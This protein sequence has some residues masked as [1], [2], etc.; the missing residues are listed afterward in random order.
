MLRYAMLASALLLTPAAASAQQIP[1]EIGQC[2]KTTITEHGTR[3]QGVADSGDIVGYPGDLYGI[4][5]GV[6]DGLKG[7]R[8][9]D[10]VKLCLVSVP[11][12]CPPGDDRG[13]VYSGFNPRTGLSWELPDAGHLCGGA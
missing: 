11:G 8:V 2:V 10:P 6:V 5:Y 12:D 4:S 9:G 1:T 13:K 7:S 3:L